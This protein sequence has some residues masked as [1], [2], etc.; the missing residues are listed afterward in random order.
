MNSLTTNLHLLLVG[1][2]QRAG[3]RRKIVI[4]GGAF[5][6][7]RLLVQSQ[8]RFH[9]F[10]P[11]EVI[12]ELQPRPGETLLRTEDIEARLELDKDDI[13]LMLMSG[14]NDY[15][16]QL[17]ELGRFARERRCGSDPAQNFGGAGVV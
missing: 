6:S 14:I 2:Y 9:G 10:D 13:A 17:F 12:I 3:R 11:D 4:E 7:D 8:A 1:F 5:P 15:T 16:G